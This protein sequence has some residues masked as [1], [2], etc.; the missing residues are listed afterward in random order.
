[1]LSIVEI[2]SLIIIFNQRINFS[3]LI[4]IEGIDFFLLPSPTQI[5]DYATHHIVYDHKKTFSPGFE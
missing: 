2:I 3:G 4:I 1:L 5:P